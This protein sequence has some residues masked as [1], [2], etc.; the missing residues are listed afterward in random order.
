MG[1]AIYRLLGLYP[2]EWPKTSAEAEAALRQYDKRAQEIQAVIAVVVVLAL[3][4]L[5]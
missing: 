2:K 4:A 5:M 3:C 1:D